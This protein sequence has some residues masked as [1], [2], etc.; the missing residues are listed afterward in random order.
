MT[1]E[2]LFAERAAAGSRYAAAVAALRRAWIDLCAL[3]QACANGPVLAAHPNSAQQFPVRTFHD[4]STFDP[5]CLSHAVFAPDV[6]HAAEWFEAA[7]AIAADHVA[8]LT[9]A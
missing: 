3:D 6:G 7:E 5:R 9:V 1:P 4:P 8:H 2:Q